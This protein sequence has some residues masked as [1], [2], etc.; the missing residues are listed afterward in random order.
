MSGGED[1]V[2]QR[3]DITKYDR[4]M[5]GRGRNDGRVPYFLRASDSRAD[6]RFDPRLSKAIVL[7][8]AL[9]SREEKIVGRELDYHSA[10]TADTAKE[11][12][13]AGRRAEGLTGIRTA[14]KGTE[15]TSE[16]NCKETESEE[17]KALVLAFMPRRP[18]EKDGQLSGYN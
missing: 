1:A 14:T 7:G 15:K 18:V 10:D 13:S 17:R 5:E 11:D 12:A 16:I 6:P 4:L 2:K 8:P 9:S 3:K